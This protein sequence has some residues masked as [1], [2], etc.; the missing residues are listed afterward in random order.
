MRE[1]RCP[2][3]Y[4]SELLFVPS[5]PAQLVAAGRQR[6]VVWDLGEPKP[7]TELE[8]RDEWQEPPVLKCSPDGRSLISGPISRPMVWDFAQPKIRKPT[9]L[10]PATLLDFHFADESNRV[11][12]V[13]LHASRGGPGLE[14]NEF[15]P[16]RGRVHSTI[17]LDV[18]RLD[19][20]MLGGFGPGVYL[21]YSSMAGSRFALSGRQKRAFV[22]NTSTGEL[23]GEIWVRVTDAMTG[24]EVTEERIILE[25]QK[26][27][28]GIP[29]AKKNVMRRDG[30]PHMEA[31]VTGATLLEKIDDGEFK[32]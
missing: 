28:D 3:D 20:A 25:Y 24:N 23:V 11:R 26:S 13:Y 6:A 15:S 31:E 17:E 21:H 18:S 29:L 7:V 22:W 2:I 12:A 9:N 16:S 1:Y 8:W 10:S 19:P 14:V 5:I 4:V 30:K 27:K 32:K